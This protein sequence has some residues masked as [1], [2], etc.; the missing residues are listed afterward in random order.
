MQKSKSIALIGAQVQY[1]GH[2]GVFIADVISVGNTYVVRAAKAVTPDNLMRKNVD[3]QAT[4]HLNDFPG[5]N[6]WR[7]DLGV[8]VVPRKQLTLTQVGVGR[9]K[10]RDSFLKKA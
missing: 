2:A 1:C 6:F 4:H 5:P 7:P 9:I 3:E 10:E 8:F